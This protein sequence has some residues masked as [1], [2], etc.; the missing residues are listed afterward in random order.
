MSDLANAVI[1]AQALYAASGGKITEPVLAVMVAVA[2]QQSAWQSVV[3]PGGAIGDPLVG[4]G[5]WQITPGTVADLDPFVCAQAT[6]ALMQRDPNNPYEPW[7]LQPDGHTL[8]WATGSLPGG[9]SIAV[10]PPTD[11]QYE[12]ATQAAAQV[13]AA[14]TQGER[15]MFIEADKTETVEGVAVKAGDL[16][17]KVVLGGVSWLHGVPANLAA[18]VPASWIV[19]DSGGGWVNRYAGKIVPAA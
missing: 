14:Q 1:A 2:G 15:Q 8:I 5:I 7:N 6:W 13:W 3:Q 10:H 17:E 9:G 4:V 16:F 12:I 11:Y 18:T 19:K